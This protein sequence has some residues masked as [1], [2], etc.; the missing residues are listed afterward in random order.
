MQLVQNGSSYN[1]NYRLGGTA[2]KFANVR[3]HRLHPQ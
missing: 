2:E 3:V 1:K